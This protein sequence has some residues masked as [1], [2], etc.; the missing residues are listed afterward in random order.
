[1]AFLYRTK[2]KGG[3]SGKIA[4]SKPARQFM[5]DVKKTNKSGI[6]YCYSD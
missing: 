4:S 6:V 1:M 5:E 3:T 2:E